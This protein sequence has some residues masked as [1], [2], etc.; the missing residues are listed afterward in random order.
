M[1][2]RQFIM[3]YEA[4]V[5]AAGGDENTMAK[6]FVIIARDIAQSWY[7]NLGPGSVESWADLRDKL[8]TNFKGISVAPSHPIDWF[9][10]KQAKRE[11]LQEYWRRF[12]HIQARTPNITDEVV[13]LAAVNCLCP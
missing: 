1:D 2:P 9:N 5:A 7:S 8:C 10:C 3:S 6:S 13:I 11:P 12:I 4:A